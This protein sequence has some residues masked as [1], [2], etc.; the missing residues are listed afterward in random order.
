MEG[1]TASALARYG[2]RGEPRAVARAA[3]INGLGAGAPGE[4]G[5]SFATGL[6]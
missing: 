2:S 3:A 6:N 4:P 5:M 1:G